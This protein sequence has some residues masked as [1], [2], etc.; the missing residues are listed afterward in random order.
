MYMAS[1]ESVILRKEH[2]M[3][4]GTFF[5]A[6]AVW[7]LI[8]SIIV[9]F[10]LLV[11]LNFEG[12][13]NHY[14][15]ANPI[16]NTKIFDDFPYP[17]ILNTHGEQHLAIPIRAI[18][19]VAGN[20][21]MTVMFGGGKSSSENYADIPA[22]SYV[23]NFHVNQTFAFRCIEHHDFT[24]LEFYKYLGT[25]IIFDEPRIILW[26]FAGETHRPMP[27]NYPEVIVHSIDPVD[28]D[29]HEGLEQWAARFWNP[30]VTWHQ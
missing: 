27:C 1:S 30:S 29:H 5:V 9:I 10:S 18:E 6:T 25:R 11:A 28:H 2:T 14:T 7:I 15:Y 17:E 22:F 4:C 12:M 8:I 21:T 23:Q 24:Y 19:H 16:Q 20:N 13:Y 3:G 26:Y